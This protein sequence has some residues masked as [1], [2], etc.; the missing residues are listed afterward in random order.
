[1]LDKTLPYIE[2]EMK[3][4]GQLPLPQVS[5]KLPAGYQLKEYQPGYETAWCAVEYA[6]G[7]FDNLEA[8][9]AYFA[10][11]FAPYPE[12]LP[13]RMA[14]I[15]DHTGAIVATCTAWWGKKGEPLLHWL[16]VLPKSQGKGLA[17]FLALEITRRLVSLNPKK[18][19]FLHTQTWSYPAIFLYE[20]LGYQ[21][22][23]GTQDFEKGRALLEQLRQPKR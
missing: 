19:L 3:R 5:R 17:T 7:E 11:T 20:K 14:F 8:A 10:K 16:A 23:P 9:A 13:R 4:P 2:F 22:L 18:D 12:E 15:T 1:M 6:V 21:L